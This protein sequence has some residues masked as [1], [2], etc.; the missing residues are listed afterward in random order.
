MNA[1]CFI[2]DKGNMRGF[3]INNLPEWILNTKIM[4]V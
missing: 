1:I 2:L 4:E 3:R